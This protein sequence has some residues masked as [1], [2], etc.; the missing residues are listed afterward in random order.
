MY[1]FNS[2]KYSI[3]WSIIPTRI[4]EQSFFRLF[5]SPEF[6]DSIHLHS[7]CQ[8]VHSC[9]STL[10]SILLRSTYTHKMWLKFQSTLQSNAK[11]APNIFRMY[12]KV[13]RPNLSYDR[14]SQTIYKNECEGL[15]VFLKIGLTMTAGRKSFYWYLWRLHF[16]TWVP[17]I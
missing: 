16:P 6:H 11:Y 15:S 8:L 9:H 2:L 1:S 5:R 3:W 14:S 12:D 13:G 17:R 4:L 7:S 10:T